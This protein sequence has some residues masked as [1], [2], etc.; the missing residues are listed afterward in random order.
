M[1]QLYYLPGACSLATQVVL[2]ELNQPHEII[3]RNSVSN[4]ETLNPY[5]TV[6]VLKDGSETLL[7]GAAIMIHLLEKHGGDWLP[8][9]GDKRRR[10][11]QDIMF[12]NATVHPAYSKLF[13]IANAIDD[14]KTRLLALEK[15]A[16]SVN[17]LWQVVNTRLAQQPFLGGQNP[18]A[19]DIMLAVYSRWNQYFPVKIVLGDR[20][21]KMIDAVLK[22]PTFIAAL[23]AEEAQQVAA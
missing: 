21:G 13:F 10:A 22:R 7:E 14:E 19:A 17:Q 16:V 4:F 9:Q 3:N 12:A 11:I 1:Y 2:R 18:S 8:K 5:R 23:Q 20:T 15:A 6:P